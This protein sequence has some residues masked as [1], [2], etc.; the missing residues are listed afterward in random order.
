MDLANFS[1]YKEDDVT[2]LPSSRKNKKYMILNPNTNKFVN[3]G[4]MG[5]MDYGWKFYYLK[6]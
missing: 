2:L 1:N 5:Y 3:F 4:A 6:T